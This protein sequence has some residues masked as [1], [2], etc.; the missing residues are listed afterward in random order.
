MNPREL[1]AELRE[2]RKNRRAI[3]I[4][5]D[6]HGCKYT[7]II[8]L[9]GA[10]DEF[11]RFD[12][13]H[14]GKGGVGHAAP[15][16]EFAI[17]DKQDMVALYKTGVGTKEVAKRFGIG[18]NTAHQYILDT[19]PSAM[20]SINYVGEEE[21]S[22][23]IRMRDSGMTYVDIGAHFN[24]NKSTVRAAYIRAKKGR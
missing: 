23:I 4:I 15:K 20:R 7:D 1:C 12:R 22:E 24:R 5:A 10:T 14:P 19:E 2:L 18:Q 9:I 3:D 6:R 11:E 8:L 21:T 13:R 17:Q 16:R